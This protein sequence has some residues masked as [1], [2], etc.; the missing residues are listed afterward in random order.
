VATVKTFQNIKRPEILYSETVEIDC[1]VVPLLKGQCE[2]G[3][4]IL[5]DWRVVE[6]HTGERFYITRDLNKDEVH[7]KLKAVKDKG[8]N[9]ISV[10]LAHSYTCHEH[11]LEIGRI[12]Q[13]LGTAVSL[14]LV[15]GTNCRSRFPA[16]LAVAPDHTNGP[17]STSRVHFIRRRLSHSSCETLRRE[18]LSRLQEQPGRHQSVVHAERRGFDPY[19]QFQRSQSHPFWSRWRSCRVRRDHVAK[20]NQPTGDRFRH[21]WYLD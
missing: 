15:L 2:L 16:C 17:D 18:F 9:S 14:G 7:D 4:S 1:R 11:E 8:I 21:G 10:A 13:K 6:G 19:A 3:D 12:A 5:K 20:R